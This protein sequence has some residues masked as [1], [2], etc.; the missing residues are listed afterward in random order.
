M[1]DLWNLRAAM[2]FAT[3]GLAALAAPAG[4]SVVL[5]PEIR[6]SVSTAD[7]QS[8]PKVAVFPDGGFVVVWNARGNA[9]PQ[10]PTVIHARLFLKSGAPS[11][12]EFLV[13]RP[14]SGS[15]LVDGVGVVGDHQFV[16][17]W[18]QIVP[19]AGTS[20]FSRVMMQLFDRGGAPVTNQ[21][22]V[23]ARAAFAPDGS[24][25][26]MVTDWGDSVEVVLYRLSPDGTFQP[27][28]Q[29][30]SRCCIDPSYDA[31]VAVGNDGIIGALWDSARPASL[32]DLPLSPIPANGI[33]GRFFVAI[34]TAL[35]DGPAAISRHPADTLV[36][37][38]LAAFANHQGFVA[39]WE[40]E[41]GR[42]GDASS[43]FGRLIAPAGI[44]TGFD[45]PVN[46]T[47]AGA[48]HSPALAASGT[49]AVAVWAT[50]PATTIYA[51]RI[52]PGT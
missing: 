52:S 37:P 21:V 4:A 36:T 18:D 8:A 48:Q 38:Q 29:L 31:A 33:S 17:L 32:G 13:V 35:R 50:E 24:L 41:S 7:V 1:K 22:A 46:T 27:I 6:V 25:L 40:D 39:I 14:L 2:F 10:T 12:G 42:D 9:G 47:T 43:I 23:H 28:D 26:T 30:D 44:P 11:S 20:P 5:G 15:A 34:G 45:F 16:V 51:R 3:C 49:T 19:Q